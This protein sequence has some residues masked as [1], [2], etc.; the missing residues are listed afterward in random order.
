MENYRFS[1]QE[2]LYFGE[3]L[4]CS[5]AKFKNIVS[6]AVVDFRITTRQAVDQAIC[7][8]VCQAVDQAVCQL[9][10]QGRLSDHMSVHL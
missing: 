9:R 6:S 4:P 2:N 10:C 8:L 5:A 7:Q 3:C 1:Y